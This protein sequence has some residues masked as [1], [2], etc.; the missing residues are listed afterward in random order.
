[1]QAS[2]PSFQLALGKAVKAR[3]AELGLSQEA[4]ANETGLNQNWI[5]HI[6]NGRRN[7]SLRSLHRLAIGLSL[8]PAALLARSERYEASE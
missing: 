3:R 8:K 7:P 4:L 1:M 2:Q 6:E 5:S